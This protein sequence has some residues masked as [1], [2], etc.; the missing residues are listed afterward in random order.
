MPRL[1]FTIRRLMI[2]VAVV[3]VI[4]GGYFWMARPRTVE[5]RMAP[6]PFRANVDHEV[7]DI[8]L[9]DLL[10]NDEFLFSKDRDGKQAA[11]IVF[12]SMT[13]EGYPEDPEHI[14]G[15]LGD[16][17]SEKKVDKDVVENCIDRNPPKVRFSLTEY[18]PSN[19]GIV[20]QDLTEEEHFLG[21]KQ[22]N[23]NRGWV[24]VQ[25]PGYSRD[26]QTALLRFTFGPTPH[27]SDGFYL[28]RKVKGRWEIIA[29]RLSYYA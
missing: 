17:V 29:K 9:T 16:L 5:L 4:L 7:F 12:S 19:P 8:V 10:V 22:S 20:V 26:G 11:R 1:R 3:S 6:L 23:P 13:E 15:Y 18:H 25:L 21:I 24:E 28:L 27:G 14:G 2:A